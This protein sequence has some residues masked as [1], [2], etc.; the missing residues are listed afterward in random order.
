MFDTLKQ[1]QQMKKLSD[2][3]KK[4]EVVVEEN[5]VT[6]TMRGDFEVIDL[7]LN[8]DL[9]TIAQQRVLM[10]LFRKAKDKIQE[11]IANNFRGSMFG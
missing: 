9:D 11:T 2:E 8:P 7:T 3:L 4:Q 10:N 6:V 5:G 1:M